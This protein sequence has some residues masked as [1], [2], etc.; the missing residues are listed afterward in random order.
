[1]QTLI[2]IFGIFCIYLFWILG[3]AVTIAL[4]FFEFNKNDE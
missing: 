1:M 4:L 3:A 2:E